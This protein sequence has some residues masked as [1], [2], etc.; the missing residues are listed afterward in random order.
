MLFTSNCTVYERNQLACWKAVYFL[1]GIV[2]CSKNQLTYSPRC[3]GIIVMLEL[4][5]AD[6][7]RTKTKITWPQFSLLLVCSECSTV[8]CSQCTLFLC[9]FTC[10]RWRRLA[11]VLSH[12]LPVRASCHCKWILTPN[13][14][15]AILL[16]NRTLIS[17]LT[18]YI[19]VYSRN[20]ACFTKERQSIQKEQI[21]ISL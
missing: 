14:G 9:I 3:Y 11:M 8:T 16:F 12:I 17:V 13:K 10:W 4:S 7:L 1:Q 20:V 2:S 5:L 6:S 18:L 19:D 15:F 21:I